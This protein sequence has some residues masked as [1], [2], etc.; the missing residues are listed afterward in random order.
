MLALC[1]QNLWVANRVIWK[2]DVKGLFVRQVR[3]VYM[4]YS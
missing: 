2:E 4:P 1:N 3:Y